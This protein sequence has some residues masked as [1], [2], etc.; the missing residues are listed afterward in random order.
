MKDSKWHQITSLERSLC[1][2]IFWQRKLFC[3][4][5]LCSQTELEKEAFLQISFILNKSRIFKRTY[6]KNTLNDISPTAYKFN[7]DLLKKYI[8]KRLQEQEEMKKNAV[9]VILANMSSKHKHNRLESFV[10]S[11]RYFV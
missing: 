11:D 8:V 3:T 6:C 5:K 1:Y 10:N 4:K 7:R 9:C 2:R